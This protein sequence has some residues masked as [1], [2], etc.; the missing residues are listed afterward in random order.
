MMEISILFSLFQSALQQQ[1]YQ[2]PSPQI[3]ILF[4]LFQS[5]ETSDNIEDAITYFHTI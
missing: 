3:S 5:Y 1:P 4:S 2:S